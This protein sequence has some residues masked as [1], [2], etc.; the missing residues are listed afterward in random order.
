MAPTLPL[1]HRMLFVRDLLRCETLPADSAM[2]DPALRCFVFGNPPQ[3]LERVRCL[4]TVVRRHEVPVKDGAVE[5][6]VYLDDGSGLIPVVLPRSME[7][8]PG[9][10]G[11]SVTWRC[12]SCGPEAGDTVE[13]FGSLH[14]GEHP[15]L[16]DVDPTQRYI[17]AA[18]WVAERNPLQE[19]YRSLEI[20]QLCA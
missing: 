2:L 18:S 6:L 4:G 8:A 16:A 11:P 17:C 5:R 3:R 13:I 1:P 15:A 10:S 20:Q 9:P 12:E 19:S 7:G 14:S